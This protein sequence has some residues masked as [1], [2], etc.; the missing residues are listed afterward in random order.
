MRTS[1]ELSALLLS[2]LRR[3]AELVGSFKQVAVDQSSE[4]RRRFKLSE[5]LEEVLLSLQPRLKETSHT[6][7]LDCA[8][9]I[10][11]DSYPGVYS[12]IV[13]QLL[14]NSLQHGFEQQEQGQIAIAALREAGELVLRYGD[15]GRGMSE[16]EMRHMFEPFYTTKRGQGCSGLGLHIVYNLVTQKLRGRIEASSLPGQGVLFTIRVPL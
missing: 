16:E 5:Y 13:S 15:D 10:E 12:Q 14:L 2:N 6:V 11:L 1:S 4:A 3:A 7:K 9:D 8:A